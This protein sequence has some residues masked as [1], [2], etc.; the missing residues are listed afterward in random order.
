MSLNSAFALSDT[1]HYTQQRYTDENG[2]P[3]N[4]VR[5][6]APDKAGFLWLATEDG[7]VR[8]DGGSRF[9]HFNK[10]D[11]GIS[12]SGVSYIYANAAHSKLFAVTDGRQVIGIDNGNAGL[13]SDTI[14]A[15]ALFGRPLKNASQRAYMITGLPDLRMNHTVIK[16]C[17]LPVKPH[18]A[19]LITSDSVYYQEGQ[20]PLYG[21]SFPHNNF[22]RFFVLGGQLYYMM[23]SGQIQGF[24]REEVKAMT[25]TGDILQ[26]AARNGARAM[27]LYWN[28]AAEEVFIY[29]EQACYILERLPD[30]RLNTRLVV[31]DVDFERNQ[32]ISVY[33]DAVHARVFLG[34]LSNGLYVF[35]RRQFS[36]AGSGS[37][38]DSGS[39]TWDK[40]QQAL[41]KFNS[42]G[43]LLR[44][45]KC[46]ASIS[47]ISHMQLETP[48]RLWVGTDNGLYCLELSSG[49][50]D[51]VRGLEGV[52]IRS[53]SISFPGR[54][55]ITTY[56][57]GIFLYRNNR[58]TAFPLDRQKCLLSSHYIIE[59]NRGYCWIAT[60]K[61]LF[62][63]A[64]GDLLAYADKRQRYIYYYRYAK[65]RGFQG[66]E[67][68]GSC[69]PYTLQRDSSNISLP[70]LDGL[71]CF[72]PAKVTPEL[73][74]KAMFIDQASLNGKPVAYRDTLLLPHAFQQLKLHVS[75]PYFG[76]PYN[77]QLTY[78]LS[79]GEED[80]LWLPL[81]SDHSLSFSTLASGS[82]RLRIRMINGFGKNNYTEKVVLFMVRQ[83]YY[84]TTWFHLLI[85]LMLVAGT[86]LYTRLRT[87]RIQ[88]QKQA[89]ESKVFAR[90]G[91]LE[92]ALASLT[93]SEKKLRRQARIQERLI[94]SITHDIKTPMKYLMMLSANMSW[95]ENEQPAPEMMARS[96]KAI[97]DAS[98]RMY[99]LIENLIRYIK[100]HVKNGSAVMEEIDLQELVEEKIDIF[101]SIA[102]A[103]STTIINKVQPDLPC[104][105]NFQLLAVVIHNLLDNAV[106]NTRDG[107]I[108]VYASVYGGKIT[109][110][111]EDSGTG[112]PPE[113]LDWIRRHDAGNSKQEEA[114]SPVQSGMGLVIVM[115]LLDMV[116]GRLIAEN[117]PYAGA[118]I[119]IE[120]DAN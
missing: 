38:A 96:A 93:L 4:T 75:V 69:Q 34:S 83:A 33:Y 101:N 117:K 63:A 15:A 51:T 91:Q 76:D 105:T 79:E 116:N 28:P 41:C 18:A 71:V 25:L 115:E 16:R 31:R 72:S 58:L 73:P 108:E 67:F 81:G 110:Y 27:A 19:F 104:Y 21:L 13:L 5:A 64:Q 77:L 36:V 70:S 95:K 80:T 37:V 85:A 102:A 118:R 107:T 120:L 55:W 87:Y 23:P 40:D 86:A 114:V 39:Y 11:L 60:N 8:F 94:A 42:R 65:E 92:S 98:Y 62:Q 17:L 45:W 12:S 103:Q 1:A 9:R 53:V 113:L 43:R 68:N 10:S 3:Q 106:K 46:R 2:L 44:K 7:L 74:G 30:G 14:A 78:T 59:D 111:I 26:H 57:D 88:Q 119:G 52:P 66:N 49:R 22:Q 89:L 54:V 50:I 32:I 35:T 82:H 112:L 99:Y 29:L 20:R 47:D 97:Y 109:I 6:I 24:Y 61:G 56:D 100:T 48:D 84:E 90:T